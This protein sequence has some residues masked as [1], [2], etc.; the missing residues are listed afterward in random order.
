[1]DQAVGAGFEPRQ[2][3]YIEIWASSS[4]RPGGTF[5]GSQTPGPMR[6]RRCRASPS[7]AGGKYSAVYKFINFV[8]GQG[9]RRGRNGGGC[10]GGY[11]RENVHTQPRRL[12]KTTGH[13]PRAPWG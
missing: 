10:G 2:S 6:R 1:M 13:L 8:G 5:I 7:F 11:R 9:G 12:L 4:C 3:E